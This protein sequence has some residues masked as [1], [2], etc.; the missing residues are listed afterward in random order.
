MLLLL[1]GWCYPTLWSKVQG[2]KIGQ[3]PEFNYP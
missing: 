2:Y 1:A 3:E